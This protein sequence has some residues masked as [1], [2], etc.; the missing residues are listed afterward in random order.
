MEPAPS[1]DG[2]FLRKNLCQS[3]QIPFLQTLSFLLP[4]RIQYPIQMRWILRGIHTCLILLATTCLHDDLP[5]SLLLFGR[6]LTVGPYVCGEVEVLS[7]PIAYFLA[8]AG[9]F[10]PPRPL[11]V[12]LISSQARSTTLARFQEHCSSAI[13]S[14]IDRFSG[15]TSRPPFL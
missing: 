1:Q 12:Y 4:D 13:T 7:D 3:H 6:R 10:E 14:C 2:S 11:R 9:G 8:E 15:Y 5:S